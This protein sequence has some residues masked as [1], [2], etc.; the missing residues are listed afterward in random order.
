MAKVEEPKKIQLRAYL[1]ADMHELVENLAAAIGGEKGSA[2][3]IVG[4]SILMFQ[5]SETKDKEKFVLE[6]LKKERGI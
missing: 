2:K 3:E 6:F 1:P 4:A 5:Q